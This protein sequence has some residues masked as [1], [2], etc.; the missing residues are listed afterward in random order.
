VGGLLTSG[1]NLESLLAG[2]LLEDGLSAQLLAEGGGDVGL[3]DSVVS[4]C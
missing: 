4:L 2:A 1:R 3:L